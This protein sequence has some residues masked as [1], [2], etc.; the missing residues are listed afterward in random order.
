M[1][2]RSILHRR[3]IAMFVWMFS[4]SECEA[5]KYG[6][7]CAN[8]CGSCKTGDVCDGTSGDCPDGCQD[9]YQEPLCVAGKRL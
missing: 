7:N 8:D 3:V 9:G 1:K 2:Y 6:E 4:P 5:G